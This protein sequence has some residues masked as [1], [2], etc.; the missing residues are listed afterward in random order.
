MDL[1]MAI[2]AM[3]TYISEIHPVVL[4]LQE[5][6]PV[7]ERLM[8]EMCG[9]VTEL[10]QFVEDTWPTGEKGEDPGVA[11]EKGP[12]HLRLTD[13]PPLLPSTADVLHRQTSVSHMA[14]GGDSHGPDVHGRN[15]DDRGHRLGNT[16][17]GAY[18]HG[19]D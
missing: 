1:T 7:I 2:S 3:S 16:S 6:R 9:E 4:E 14:Q 15:S 17:D 10:C 18:G 13:L 11:K 12:I 8:E 19:Y 5:W